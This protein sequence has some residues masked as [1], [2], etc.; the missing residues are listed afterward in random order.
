MHEYGQNPLVWT[1]PVE[2]FLGSSVISGEE[3]RYGIDDL[4]FDYAS[5]ISWA[6]ELGWV[7][8]FL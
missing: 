5:A 3:D 2:P 4:N 1:K 7:I 6:C 8:S